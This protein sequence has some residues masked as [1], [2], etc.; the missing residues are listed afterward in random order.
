MDNTKHSK[1]ETRGL[2]DVIKAATSSVGIPPCAECQKRA[3]MLNLVSRRGIIGGGLLVFL[4]AK[5]A[6]VT[7]AW[8]VAGAPL[9]A[10]EQDLVLGFLRT[11][12]TVQRKHYQE[13]GTHYLRVEDMH[14]DIVAHKAHFEPGTLAYAWA[15]VYRPSSKEVLPGWT[16]DFA[17][18]EYGKP[19]GR[20]D[21]INGYRIILR[22]EDF[23]FI[24]DEEVGIY[25]ASVSANMPAAKDLKRAADFPGAIGLGDIHHEGAPQPTAWERIKDFLT[26]KVY[27]A[28][29]CM[30]CCNSSACCGP[31]W[32]GCTACIQDCCN[33]TYCTTVIPTSGCW[34]AAGCVGSY[35][36]CYY[37]QTNCGDCK[38][39]KC[40]KLLGLSCCASG[41]GQSCPTTRGC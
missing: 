15:S 21:N 23:V 16:L 40:A 5:N 34:F 9:P 31:M 3:D 14:A 12:S 36:N 30:S 13:T 35:L 39:N 25:R 27:A 38:C 7:A 6:L 2:G 32:C 24:T 8:Q 18:V 19:T 20:E 1:D 41:C 37:Y 4:L 33:S 10:V 22:G 26:P 17:A 29:F 28:F 11:A